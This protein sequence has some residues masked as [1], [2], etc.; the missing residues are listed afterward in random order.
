MT[1]GT[2]LVSRWV[3]LFPHYKK[4][5]TQLGFRD[6]IVTS[7]EKDSLN[8]VINEVKP[9]LLL[10]CSC[11]YKAGTPYMMGQLHKNFPRLSI[12]A[13]NLDDFPDDMAPWFI[14]Y[15]VASYVNEKEGIEEFNFGMEEVRQGR[16]YIAP[17]VKEIFENTEWPDINDKA[18][19]RQ[20]EVLTFLCNGMA[21]LLIGEQLHISKRTVDWHIEELR[22]VFGVQ[23]REELISMAFYLDI[24]TKDDLCFFD[25]K[26][27]NKPLPRW[28]VIKQRTKYREQIAKKA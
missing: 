27:K 14:W 17:N 25:R 9:R 10:V 11:F 2:L 12:A 21:P 28:A 24:V 13:I 22:K 3:K 26:L 4:R 19:K 6:V 5:L 18:D 20:L 16:K 7:E 15:G 23:N 8:M 1:G